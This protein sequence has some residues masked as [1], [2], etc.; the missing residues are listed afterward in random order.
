MNY[1]SKCATVLV[2]GAKF[3]HECGFKQNGLINKI[4]K[5]IFSEGNHEEVQPTGNRAK[6]YSKSKKT[7]NI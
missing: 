3:C 6:K 2:D 7:K 4:E 5:R 1:C